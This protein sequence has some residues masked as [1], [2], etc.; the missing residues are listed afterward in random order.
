MSRSHSFVVLGIY[1]IYDSHGFL[2]NLV[3]T[4]VQKN[5]SKIHYISEGNQTCAELA[6]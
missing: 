2:C 4:V 3:G 5:G 1:Q 6:V